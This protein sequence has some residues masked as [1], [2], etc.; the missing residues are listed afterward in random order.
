VELGKGVAAALAAEGAPPAGSGPLARERRVA[1]LNKY[2]FA[3]AT[4][5]AVEAFGPALADRQE[6][7]G[8]LADVAIEAYAVDS[9]VARALQKADP[10]GQ[11]CVRLYAEEAHLRAF[12]R[13]RAAVLGSV[14]E[15]A[16]ARKHL[17]RL[18]RLLD[19]EPGDLAGW[20]DTVAAATV[21]AGKYPLAWA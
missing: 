2:L 7:M 10:V 15:P 8:A 20:R 1:E 4:Q 13:A 3:Y 21:E 18:R 11:A 9:A 17:G 16:A 6:V 14:K 12:G 5:V 19:E